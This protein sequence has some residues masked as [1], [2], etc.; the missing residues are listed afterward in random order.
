MTLLSLISLRNC[1][2]VW[3]E[4]VLQPEEARI[5]GRFGTS[6]LQGAPAE[7][8]PARR[9]LAE[10]GI[11]APAD[12]RA[13]LAAA[14][15]GFADANTRVVER[16]EVGFWPLWSYE[17]TPDAL[18]WSTLLGM[19]SYDRDVERFVRARD[20]ELDHAELRVAPADQGLDADDP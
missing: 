15:R 3:N 5:L 4:G 10:H 14:I 16:R 13:A 1:T 18:R 19:A 9:V 7:G 2:C 12:D 20:L 8:E 6:S 17:R 11:E